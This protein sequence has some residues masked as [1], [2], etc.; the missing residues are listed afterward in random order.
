[1]QTS[2]EDAIKSLPDLKGVKTSLQQL[3]S[4]EKEFKRLFDEYSQG[5][6]YKQ[7]YLDQNAFLVYY[8][9]GFD[10]PGRKV[11]HV[12]PTSSTFST[13]STSL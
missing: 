13:L 3:P 6:S 7:V 12:L 2:V 4:G 8:T 11:N 9:K 1:M 10:G 5:V